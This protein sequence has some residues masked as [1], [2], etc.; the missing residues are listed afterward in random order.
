MLSRA[1]QLAWHIARRYHEPLTADMI[2]RANH[3]RPNDAMNLFR[4]AFG[5]TIATFITQHRITHAQRLLV[6]TKGSI[7]NIA[8]AAGFQSLSRFHEAFKKVVCGC[9]PRDY[10]KTHRKQDGD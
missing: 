8:P 7:L 5:T 3:L 9:S 1:D 2:V 4:K 6:T 10:R